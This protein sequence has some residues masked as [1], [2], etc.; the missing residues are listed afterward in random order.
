MVESPSSQQTQRMTSSMLAFLVPSELAP[1]AARYEFLSEMGQG[2]MGRVYQA[3]DNET[4]DVVALKVLHPQ[5]ASDPAMAERFKNEL[6]LARRITHKNVCRIFDFNRVDAITYITMECVD[7]ETLRQRID[8]A[9]AL[10]VAQAVTVMRQVCAGLQEAHAEGI[11]HRDLKPENIMITPTGVVKLM[12]F[13]IARSLTMG[14]NTAHTL[15]GTPA[16]MA[17]EQARGGQIDARTDVYALGLVL[18]ECLT[19]KRAFTGNTPVDVALKQIQERPPAPRSLNADVPRAIEAAVLRCLEKNPAQRFASVE[20][21]VMEL[22]R[23]TTE[24]T[25]ARTGMPASRRW[26]LRGIG[27]GALLVIAGMAIVQRLATLDSVAP[28]ATSA[29][30]PAPAAAKPADQRT[31]F[32]KLVAAAEAGNATAQYKL[33]QSYITGPMAMRND[34]KAA[35]WMQRAAERGNTEAQFVLGTMYGMGRGVA[36]DPAK[37]QAWYQRAADAGHAGAREALDRLRNPYLNR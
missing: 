17:P 13:G 18:Y 29:V 9:G 11:V 20:A 23:V 19:G 36:R 21:L 3:R 31:E 5:I 24:S 34:T 1:L 6:R 22:V 28:S 16:Y 4:G 15:I 7:G 14:T 12:D 35:A 2:G 37:A 30:V 33:A 10:P 32:Q 25:S 26:P 8:R 27:I